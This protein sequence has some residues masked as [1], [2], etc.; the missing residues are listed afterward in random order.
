M[1]LVICH[2]IVIGHC[3]TIVIIILCLLLFEFVATE[4]DSSPLPPAILRARGFGMTREFWAKWNRGLAVEYLVVRAG[5]N[6]ARPRFPLDLQSLV[7]PNRL[8]TEVGGEKA[9]RDL[10]NVRHRY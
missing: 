3:K 5:L 10:M 9:V 1:S 6:S 2:S 4:R 8:T 7:I